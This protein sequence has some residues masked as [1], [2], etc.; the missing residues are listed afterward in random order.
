MTPFYALHRYGYSLLAQRFDKPDCSHSTAWVKWMTVTIFLS[1]PLSLSLSL[2][3]SSLFH[4]VHPPFYPPHPHFA[5]NLPTLPV[6]IDKFNQL[7]KNKWRREKRP[8][9][10]IIFAEGKIWLTGRQAGEHIQC[11]HS[12]VNFF[13]QTPQTVSKLKPGNHFRKI[14]I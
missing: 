7:Q 3:H 12:D 5:A 13:L 2:S 4:S 14:F 1:S 11:Q 10:G 8:L 9:K 6:Q